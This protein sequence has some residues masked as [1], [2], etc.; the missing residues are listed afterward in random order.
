[1]Y[2]V[3]IAKFTHTQCLFNWP[4]VM[5]LLQAQPDQPKENVWRQLDPDYTML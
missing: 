5:E 1:M 3:F 2:K 4:P